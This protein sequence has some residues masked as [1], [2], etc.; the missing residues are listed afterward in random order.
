[1]KIYTKGGD[2]GHTSLL[3]GTRVSKDNQRI[4]AYGTVD[5]LNAHIGL[6]LSYQPAEEHK[7]I[8]IQIQRK[9]FDAGSLLAK[10]EKETSF[11]LPEITDFDIEILEKEIDR[12]N[13]ILPILRDF[14]IPGGNMLSAQT[15]VA[16]TVCRRA[17]REIIRIPSHQENLSVI[18]KY[19]NRLSDY[20]FVLSRKFSHESKLKEEKWKE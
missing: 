9:L 17:E 7:K 18:V 12:L 1:M 3:T 6:L 8:L 2:K 4:E 11:S 19:M 16:R 14:I 5:E 20:L 10:D 15:H 13:E